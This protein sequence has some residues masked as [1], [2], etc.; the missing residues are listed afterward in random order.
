MFPFSNS[1]KKKL[2]KISKRFSKTINHISLTD[3]LRKLEPI[4]FVLLR[5]FVDIL[6]KSISFSPF[7]VNETCKRR[8]TFIVSRPRDCVYLFPFFHHDLFTNGQPVV[9]LAGNDCRLHGYKSGGVTFRFQSYISRDKIYTDWKLEKIQWASSHA[10]VTIDEFPSFDG[11]ECA[12][13]SLSVRVHPVALG[14][15]LRARLYKVSL[16][17]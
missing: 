12:Q 15:P 4:K 7:F 10:L 6:S 5:L 16:F 9:R 17:E 3:L 13:R 11:T 2:E 1:K 8:L 14:L